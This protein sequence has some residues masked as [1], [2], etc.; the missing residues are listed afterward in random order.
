MELWDA[1]DRHFNQLGTDLVRGEVIPDGQYHLVVEVA[2][3]HEDGSF[4][5]MQRDWEKKGAPGLYEITAGGSVLKGEDQW[6]GA[7]RELQEETGILVD[8]LIELYQLTHDDNHT[9]YVGYYAKTNA[10]KDSIVLQVGETI[11]YQWIDKEAVESFLLSDQA[12]L[13]S[14]E[15]ML[16]HIKGYLN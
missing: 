3:Q 4:L 15:R 5:A 14:R 9:H 16:P 13:A 10:D 11:G 1:Y 8:E 2:L 6:N 7:V 12:A